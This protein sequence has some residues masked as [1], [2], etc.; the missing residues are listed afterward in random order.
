MLSIIQQQTVH[1]QWII[2]LVAFFDFLLYTHHSYAERRSVT[3]YEF[4]GHVTLLLA[5]MRGF[6]IIVCTAKKKC[7]MNKHERAHTFNNVLYINIYWFVENGVAPVL[8]NEWWQCWFWL[9]SCYFFFFFFFVV[10]ASVFAQEWVV[11]IQSISVH[12]I[13]GLCAWDVITKRKQIPSKILDSSLPTKNS[14]IE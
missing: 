5:L 11:H 6:I 13:N 2:N 1:I 14:Y 9:Q 12:L 10:V 8:I 4:D 7:V 3:V